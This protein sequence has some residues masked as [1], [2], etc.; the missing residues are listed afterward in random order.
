MTDYIKL[1][2]DTIILLGGK[3]DIL[4]ALDNPN[5]VDS[6]EIIKRFNESKMEELANRFQ[7]FDLNH[8]G[9]S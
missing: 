5:G 3:G 4:N 6:I 2:K 7:A 1:L 9:E 8:K